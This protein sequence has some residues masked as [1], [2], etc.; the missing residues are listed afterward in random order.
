MEYWLV[1]VDDFSK[2][3]VELAGIDVFGAVLEIAEE[4]A[5]FGEGDAGAF[6]CSKDQPGKSYGFEVPGYGTSYVY[7]GGSGMRLADCKDDDGKSVDASRVRL[8]EDM[9][10]LHRGSGNVI[11]SDGHVER[12]KI[13]LP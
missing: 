5:G 4:S 7:C 8:L 13:P 12:L 2:G 9:A 11:Y 3:L 6:R 1:L 10:Y